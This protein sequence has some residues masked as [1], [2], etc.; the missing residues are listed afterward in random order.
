LHKTYAKAF[1][2]GTNITTT[3]VKFLLTSPVASFLQT[4]FPYPL[5]GAHLKNPNDV[6]RWHKGAPLL[7]TAATILG[8]LVIFSH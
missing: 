8:L 7:I 6:K 4:T 1:M 3:H 2:P 5:K